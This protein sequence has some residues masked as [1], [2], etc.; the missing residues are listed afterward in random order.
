[1]N[2]K[3]ITLLKGY[4]YTKPSGGKMQFSAGLALVDEALAD[5]LMAYGYAEP[6]PKPPEPAPIEVAPI[7]EPHPEE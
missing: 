3:Y 6:F 2:D 1:M 4:T 7:E 5:E